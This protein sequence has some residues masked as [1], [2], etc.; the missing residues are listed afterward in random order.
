MA[1]VGLAGFNRRMLITS[2][3]W[4]VL[5]LVFLDVAV[6]KV[7]DLRAAHQPVSVLRYAQIAFWIVL[8]AF[9]VWSLWRSWTR[10][11]AEG[12]VV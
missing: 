12:T 9:W 7:T 1:N 10:Y 5:C 2:A 8:L 3:V 11:R 6:A 4:I